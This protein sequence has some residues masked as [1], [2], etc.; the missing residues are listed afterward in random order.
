MNLKDE[1][2]SFETC[3]TSEFSLIFLEIFLEKFNE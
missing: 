1:G 2:H 3:M